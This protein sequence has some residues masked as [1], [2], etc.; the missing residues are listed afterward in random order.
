MT[1]GWAILV[2]LSAMSALY[3]FGVLS[4]DRFLPEKCTLPS[5]MGCLDF[6]YTTSTGNL[7]LQIHNSM[8]FDMI[9]T[10]VIIKGNVICQPLKN[11]LKTLYMNSWNA[12]EF[13]CDNFENL[14]KLKGTIEFNYTNE[15]SGFTHTKEGEIIVRL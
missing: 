10:S 2:V 12:Y 15:R 8:S 11:N 1:Y 9:N 14:N 7:K 4:P 3:Y 13:K 5:G 6:S